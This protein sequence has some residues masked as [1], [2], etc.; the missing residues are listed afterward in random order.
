MT[1]PSFCTRASEIVY[2]TPPTANH[3]PP[4]YHMLVIKNSNGV[5]SVASW[6]RLDSSANLTPGTVAGKVTDSATSSAILGASVAYSGG[7]TTTDGNGDYSFESVF[8]GEHTFTA[9]ASGYA[10]QLES[11]TVTS[12]G[13]FT[14]NFALAAPGTIVG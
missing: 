1:R 2:I 6:L 9:S 4:G 3:A 5:P 7:A 10:S 12:G 8:P 14:L 13:I 11:Q